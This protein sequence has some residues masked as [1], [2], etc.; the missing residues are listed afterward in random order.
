MPLREKNALFHANFNFLNKE[1]IHIVTHEI[2]LPTEL[3][4]FVNNFSFIL[5]LIK[6][7]ES[8]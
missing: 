7:R 1:Y 3:L 2:F 4:Q 8:L 5:C 6:E